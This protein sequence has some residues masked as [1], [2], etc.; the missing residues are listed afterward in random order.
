MCWH[1]R[2]HLLLAIDQIAGIKRGN[3]EAMAVR[4][5]IRGTRLDAIPALRDSAPEILLPSAARARPDNSPLP[6]EQASPGK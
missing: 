1:G 6:S 4:D 3:L 5:R 2:Q